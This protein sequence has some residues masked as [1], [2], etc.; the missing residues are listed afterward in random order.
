[1]VT[2][3]SEIEDKIKAI[4]SG[5]DDFLSKPVNSLEL[6]TRVKSLLKIKNYHDELDK[7]QGTN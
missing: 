7:K 1:M 5:A 3:L 6:H 2:A 4:E